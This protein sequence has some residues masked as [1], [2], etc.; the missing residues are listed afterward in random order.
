MRKLF[1][2]SIAFVLT[3]ALALTSLVV[4]NTTEVKAANNYKYFL[5]PASQDD[6]KVLE[7]GVSTEAYAFN[8][9]TDSTVYVDLVALYADTITATIYNEAGAPVDQ[10][11][12]TVTYKNG[13]LYGFEQF[14]LA[15]GN[16]S[17]T[18]TSTVQNAVYLFVGRDLA[19]M[20][21]E[22][23]VVTVG[24]STKL[25][26]T[27]GTVKAWKTSNGKV[28]KVDKNGKVTGR[29]AGKCK[30]TAILTSGEKVTCTV[31]VKKNVYSTRKLTTSDVYYGNSAANVYNMSYDKKGNLVVRVRFVNN[32]GYKV[33]KLNK[34]KIVVKNS[35]GKVIGTYSGS[36]KLSVAH[37]GA[38][39]FTVTIKKSKLKIKKVQDLVNAEATIDGE[40]IYYR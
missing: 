29:K 33:V 9:D 11:A 24:F 3:L 38:K 27:G 25:D 31:T 36:Q 16:Y 8:V 37:G 35:A 2:K 1:K 15:A 12:I 5:Q 34:M 40:S 21:Q 6:V 39:D 19:K 18:L 14:N 4:M 20:S 28:A 26:V 23:A 32:I 17:V 22:T 10:K 7:A 13:D 30:I